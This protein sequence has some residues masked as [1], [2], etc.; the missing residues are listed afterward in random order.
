VDSPWIDPYTQSHYGDY[1]FGAGLINE[2]SRDELI[3]NETKIQSLID[4]DNYLGAFTE[5]IQITQVT[6]P[7]LTGYAT[8]ANILND[9]L[10]FVNMTEF[11]VANSTRRALHV[12]SLEFKFI[13]AEQQTRMEPNFM[14][15]A[16]PKLDILLE[17][18]YKFLV[19]VGNVDGTTN[20][21][22]VQRML[23][24][25]AWSGG[26]DLVGGARSIWKVNDKTAGYKTSSG[27]ATLVIVR[28]A[29]HGCS[30]ERPEEV[31]DAV[32]TFTGIM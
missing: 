17:A 25:L 27:N 23:K 3:A 28:N 15:S 20:H 30:E 22:G 21:L 14:R 11:A 26:R 4:E 2:D 32:N 18:G 10:V 9:D 13:S 19:Y 31:L 7:A 12:G 6:A 29:G 1:L 8:L 5:V 24:S 16:K